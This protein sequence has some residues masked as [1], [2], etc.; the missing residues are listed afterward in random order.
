MSK[1]DQIE[2]FGVS[3]EADYGYVQALRHG[4]TIYLSGQVAHD[5][6][7]LVAP[8]P[9]EAGRPADTANTAAQMRQ[10]YANAATLL[11]RFG[12]SLDDVVDEVL[13]VVDADE[14]DRA[15]KVVRK[16]AYGRPDP[17]V[18][19]TMIGIS[20]LAFPELLVEIKLIA[21]I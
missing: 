6:P 9:V 4:G 16:E 19:S 12:A 13:Y 8:A 15:A 11:A 18:A 3:W 7:A 14:G 1:A 17:Q 2:R 21:R 5:G 10:C 20:R